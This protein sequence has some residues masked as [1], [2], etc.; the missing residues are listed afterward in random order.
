MVVYLTNGNMM[1]SKTIRSSFAEAA[2]PLLSDSRFICP[3]K[4]FA[5]NMMWVEELNNSEFIMKHNIK[6]PI[7]RYRYAEAKASYFTWLSERSIRRVGGQ[8]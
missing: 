4:S 7:P 5:L 1:K 6:V 8:Q 2:A 3:H